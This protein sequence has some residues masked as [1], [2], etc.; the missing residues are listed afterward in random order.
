MSCPVP[1]LTKE[2]R[3]NPCASLSKISALLEQGESLFLI[4]IISLVS[5]IGSDCG[6]E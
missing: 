4:I 3:V 2:L 1:Q 5:G 6:T